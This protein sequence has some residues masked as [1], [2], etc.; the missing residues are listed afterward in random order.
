VADLLAVPDLMALGARTGAR[1]RRADENTVHELAGASGDTDV[2]TFAAPIDPTGI[3]LGG[4][5]AVGPF[6]RE[7]K[8]LIVSDMTPEPDLIFTISAVAEAPG[9]V[10][11]LSI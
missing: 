3:A 9:I 5:V 11:D 8:R 4:L 7:V 2:L 6:N 10:P 1:I